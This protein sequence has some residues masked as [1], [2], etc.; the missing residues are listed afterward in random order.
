AR[1][2]TS[3]EAERPR[4]SLRLRGVRLRPP[5]TLIQDQEMLLDRRR[6]VG[7]GVHPDAAAQPL[8]DALAVVG[9]GGEPVDHPLVA[10]EDSRD[11]QLLGHRLLLSVDQ[12]LLLVWR[13]SV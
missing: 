12:H 2:A 9:I 4:S 13:R 8:L 10:A 6:T 1:P 11:L 7:Q 3:S 5:R